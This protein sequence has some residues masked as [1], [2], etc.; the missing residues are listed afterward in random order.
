MVAFSLSG[1]RFLKWLGR[2]TYYSLSPSQVLT[3]VFLQQRELVSPAYRPYCTKA[4]KHMRASPVQSPPPATAHPGKR[5]AK[6]GAT[7]SEQLV[8]PTLGLSLLQV[9][10]SISAI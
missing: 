1:T 8:K 5:I 9:S 2:D 4:I 6:V 7:L 3:T 10:C